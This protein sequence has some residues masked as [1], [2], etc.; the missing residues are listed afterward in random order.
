MTIE[1]RNRRVYNRVITNAEPI[2]FPQVNLLGEIIRDVSID[3]YVG[4]DTQ[5]RCV[6]K[7]HCIKC[8]QELILSTHML[9]DPRTHLCYCDN[10]GNKRKHKHNTCNYNYNYTNNLGKYAKKKY[11]FDIHDPE[12]KPLFNRWV[13][14]RQRCNNPNA[15][16]YN[17]YG[18]RGIKVCPEWDNKED[19]FLNFYT[20]AI[21]S[22]WKADEGLSIDRIDVDKGYSPDNCRWAND[23]LQSSNQTK[24]R[25]IQYNQWIF[26]L[27]IW[28]KLAGLDYYRFYMRLKNGW[29]FEKAMFT[30]TNYS[31]NKVITV[32]DEYELY[33]KYQEWVDNGKILPIDDPLSITHPI[34][35][36]FNI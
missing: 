17:H 3:E 11:D 36:Y 26:P 33:N 6:Y 35:T 15:V 23:L 20:W 4:L 9:S 18:G 31:N 10:P 12:I 13:S 8:D 19:G 29:T 32:P 24:N 25:F 30:K 2:N 28:A 16:G 1:E 5:H 21:N 7:C 34:I 14:M 27:N 22:E